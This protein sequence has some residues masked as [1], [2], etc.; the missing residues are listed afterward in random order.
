MTLL[1]GYPKTISRCLIRA[2][3]NN[4]KL[5]KLVSDGDPH[6]AGL[7][8]SIGSELRYARNNLD[9]TMRELKH[10]DKAIKDLIEEYNA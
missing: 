7:V 8:M 3:K 10:V 1:T 4:D 9:H 5:W 2:I 6:I